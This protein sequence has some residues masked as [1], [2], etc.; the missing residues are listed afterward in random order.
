MSAQ[1]DVVFH[2]RNKPIQDAI[3]SRNLKQALQL[4]DKRVKKGEDTRFLKVCFLL[5]EIQCCMLVILIYLV[6]TNV[7]RHGELTF[8]IY[9][10]MRHTRNRALL[11]PLICVDL[12][13]RPR[14]WILWSCCTQPFASTR[15]M[16]TSPGLSGKRQQRR[17][18]RSWRFS[19]SG[20]QSHLRRMTGNLPRRYDL[21]LYMGLKVLFADMLY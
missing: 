5:K 2:R 19:L 13:L 12:S 16:M 4:I 9:I 6:D 14:I 11:P 18:R 21:S 1:T 7:N 15:A 10:Q 20:S 3:D 17:S 8:C